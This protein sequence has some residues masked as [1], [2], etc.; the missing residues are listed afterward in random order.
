[1]K[2]ESNSSEPVTLIKGVTTENFRSNEMSFK[3]WEKGH[4]KIVLPPILVVIWNNYLL[5]RKN[6]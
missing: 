6:K 4:K 2:L 3:K 5:H 1:L